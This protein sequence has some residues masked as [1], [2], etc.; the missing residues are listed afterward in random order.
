MNAVNITGSRRKLYRNKK[1]FLI[2][3][4]AVRRQ[5]DFAIPALGLPGRWSISPWS[6]GLPLLS[7]AR[8]TDQHLQTAH[9]LSQSL[10]GHEAASHITAAPTCRRRKQ[11][12]EEQDGAGKEKATSCP[13]LRLFLRTLSKIW[14]YDMI[15]QASPHPAGCHIQPT[16]TNITD[17]EQC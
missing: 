15:H 4:Q 13:T 14:D 3:L 10:L 1:D 2:W 17:P 8:T 6:P 7:K 12:W 9:N 16:T 5:Q 11:S